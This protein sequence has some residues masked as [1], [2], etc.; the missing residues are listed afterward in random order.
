MASTIA[1]VGSCNTDL[2][3]YM[4]AFPRPGETITG[5]AFSSGFGGKGANQCVMAAKL[6]AGPSTAAITAVH[7]VGAVGDDTFGAATLANFDACGVARAHIKTHPGVAS[8]V[9]PIWVDASGQNCIVVVPGANNL[10]SPADVEAALPS[11]LPARAS[12]TTEAS[13]ASALLCQLEIPEAAT[14][15][16][17]RYARSVGA[18]TVFT[19]APAPPGP[20]SSEFYTLTD[21]LVPNEGEA[22][23]LVGGD[24]PSAG[25]VAAARALL[26]RG[27]G[28]VVVTLGSRGSLVATAGGV[29]HHVPAAAVKA[30]VDTTGAGDA[31]AGSLAFFY[32]LLKAGEGAGVAASDTPDRRVNAAALL[33][34]CRRAAFVAADS[35]SKPGTQKS[36]PSRSELPSALFEAGEGDGGAAAVAAWGLPQPRRLED[37]AVD[38]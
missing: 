21:V 25:P 7:M 16:A 18:L 10:V 5:N 15:A 24:G 38:V 22:A 30:V 28:A 23:A 8:G 9:A 17:L 19:P 33:E 27:A 34:A 36:F 29:M 35:V 4:G 14:L 13:P 37:G 2:I 11:I 26:A 31:F 32:C 20:L 6:A 1:V 3:A 12:S